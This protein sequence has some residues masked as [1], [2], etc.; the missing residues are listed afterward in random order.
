MCEKIPLRLVMTCVDRG[1]LDLF[2]VSDVINIRLLQVL[3]F[4]KKA[5]TVC[6]PFTLRNRGSYHITKWVARAHWYTDGEDAKQLPSTD[7]ENRG[8]RWRTKLK[9][10]FR[11]EPG[12]EMGHSFAEPGMVCQY[13]ACLFPFRTPDFHPTSNPDKVLFYGKISLSE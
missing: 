8:S 1:A 6:P 10:E 2:C 11:R 4:G 3:A 13:Y 9:G 7:N 12:A 5:A